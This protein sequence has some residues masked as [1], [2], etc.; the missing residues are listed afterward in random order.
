MRADADRHVQRARK[1]RAGEALS[2]KDKIIHEQGLVSVLRELHDALDT[3]VFEAY[4]W[5][6]LA[7]ALVGRPGATS[8]LPENPPNRPPPKKNC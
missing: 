3:A 8:P 4:G 1:L 6:D 2:A 5:A 7:P